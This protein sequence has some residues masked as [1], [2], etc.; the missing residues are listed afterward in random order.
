MSVRSVMPDKAFEKKVIT[1][2]SVL[3]ETKD[4]IFIKFDLRA[5]APEPFGEKHRMSFPGNGP[6]EMNT[7]VCGI[8]DKKRSGS[9][10]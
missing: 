10:F 7:T 1:K 6:V 8:Y 2:Y 9:L 4:N 3:F 5:L